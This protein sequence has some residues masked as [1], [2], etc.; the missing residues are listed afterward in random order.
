[1]SFSCL[2][3]NWSG[4]EVREGPGPVFVVFFMVRPP[5]HTHQGRFDG[6]KSRTILALP[7]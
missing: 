1:M 3:D 4:R 5:W 6:R 2:V 7:E